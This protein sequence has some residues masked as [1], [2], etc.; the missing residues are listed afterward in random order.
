MKSA[1]KVLGACLLLA[2]A[3]GGGCPADPPMPPPEA[4]L[5]GTWALSAPSSADLDGKVFVFD[6]L[7]KLIEIR[8]T[9]GNS[10]LVE[11][12]VHESTVV[13]GMNVLIKTQGNLIFE[14]QFNDAFTVITG[15]LRTELNIPFS[16]D[17]LLTDKGD[18]VLT[19]Q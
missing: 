2:A 16:N 9:L 15:R 13:S 19:K 14:G 8:T 11:R 3:M 5:F 17:T 7:G 18:G 1:R 6:G 4:A 10:T 12:D